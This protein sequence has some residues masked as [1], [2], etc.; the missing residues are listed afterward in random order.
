MSFGVLALIV[1]AGLAGPLLSIGR[2]AY[3]PVVVGELFA[4]VVIGRTGG[5]WLDASEPTTAFLAAVGFAMLMFGAGML[6]PIRAP[7]IAGGLRRG[8]AAALLVGILAV[9]AGVGIAAAVG[10]G[11]AAIYCLLVASG[12]AA[13][14]LPAIQE[15]RLGADA[16]ALVVMSQV[17]IADVAAIFALPFVI[18]PDRAREAAVG[19]V[20][21]VASGAAVFLVARGLHDSDVVHRFRKASKRRAWALDL[22][23][24]LLMLFVLAW[25]AERAGTSI[26]VA[27]FTV[28]LLV[29]I[30]G[31]PKRLSKQV[32]GI[33]AGF[34]VP[35]FFVV[36]GARLDLRALFE[37]PSYLSLA[38]LLV[39]VNVT[40]HVAGAL[41]TRQGLPA[42]L[43]AT[44]QLGLPAA[45]VAIGLSEEV[46]TPGQGAAIILAALVSIALCTVGVALMSRAARALQATV[47]DGAPD[48]A[49]APHEPAGADG[50]ALG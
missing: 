6:V 3:V 18:Q 32:I 19:A 30:I 9:P 7:G 48:A 47:T 14:L 29:A 26:L 42:A 22:R 31:G 15:T 25:V 5:G 40:V 33:A 24:A 16:G 13:V 17:A 23:L 8:A 36:L 50:G 27:G 49:G 10:G 20:A 28:G 35:L 39:I 4:G 12:S 34:F 43:A 1:A 2:Q 45:V 21:V 11:D 37:H 46:I 41:L 38:A 44:A